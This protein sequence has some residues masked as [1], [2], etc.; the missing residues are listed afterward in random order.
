MLN[1]FCGAVSIKYKTFSHFLIE[2]PVVLLLRFERF[3]YSCCK[4]FI[5][6]DL[7]VFSP[8]L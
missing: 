3:L 1:I 5:T 6:Y 4:I 2:L 8:S 7:Q